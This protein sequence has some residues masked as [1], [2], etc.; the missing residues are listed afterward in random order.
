[1]IAALQPAALSKT[2]LEGALQR[3]ASS[4][5]G[6]E[7]TITVE[8]DERQLP[9]APKHR[10]CASPKAHSETYPNTRTPPG[11]MSRCPMG[12]KEIRLDIVDDGVGFNP[13]DVAERPAGLGHIGLDAMKQRAAE[14]GGEV[15]VESSPGNGT[16]VA[17]GITRRIARTRP[18]IL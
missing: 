3:V 15:S 6:T 12:K 2:S 4:L 7:V 17:C 11:A 13:A 5:D 16:A 9:I 14:Q 10:C 18:V 8:G 1:M